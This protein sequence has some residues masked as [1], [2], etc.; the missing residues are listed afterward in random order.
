[1][2]AAA[3]RQQPRSAGGK[4]YLL[5]FLEVSDSALPKASGRAEVIASRTDATN[6][7]KI[8][9]TNARSAIVF[10]AADHSL[11]L[12]RHRDSSHDQLVVTATSKP[13]NKSR[14]LFVGARF[15]AILVAVRSRSA[16]APPHLFYRLIGPPSLSRHR[17]SA[18][19][20]WDSSPVVSS[21]NPGSPPGPLGCG[22]S[23]L[24]W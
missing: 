24:S 16:S 7:S 12:P 14:S 23:L 13:S 17:L 15:Q 2:P 22:S 4:C 9:W 10:R 8:M 19:F 20:N 21:R 11:C 1:M 18:T 3:P 5:L 6:A